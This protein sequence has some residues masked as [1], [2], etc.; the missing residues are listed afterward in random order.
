[1]GPETLFVIDELV[2]RLDALGIPYFIGA[3]SPALRTDFPG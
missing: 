3:P 2:K 1:M